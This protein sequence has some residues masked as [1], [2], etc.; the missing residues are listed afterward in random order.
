MGFFSSTFSVFDTFPIAAHISFIIEAHSV[1]C[2]EPWAPWRNPRFLAG[3]R[4]SGLS[5]CLFVLAPRGACVL[6]TVWSSAEPALS[7]QQPTF[8]LFTPSCLE[9]WAGPPQGFVVP[10]ATPLSEDTV[11]RLAP[12]SQP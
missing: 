2:K 9:S 4:A 6:P 5:V 11:A 7:R 12:L 8:K 10:S 1:E 3:G